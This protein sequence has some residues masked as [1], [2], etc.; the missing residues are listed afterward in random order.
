MQ[1][2]RSISIASTGSTRVLSPGQKRF[3]SLILKIGVQRKLLADWN[4]VSPLLQRRHSA[5]FAPLLDGYAELNAKLVRLLDQ[6]ADAKSLNKAERRF[7]RQLICRLAGPLIDGKHADQMKAIYNRHSRTDFDSDVKASKDGLKQM[8][9]DEFG[10]DPA[11]DI[12]DATSPD[13]WLARLQDM[14][15]LQMAQQ[16]TQREQAR[17]AQQ[18][19]QRKP[20]AKQAKAK[21]EEHLTSQS[22]REVYRKL[23]SALHPDREPDAAERVRKTGL[24]QRV[25]QAYEKNDLLSL[26]QLQLEIEQIDQNALDGIA[27]D[28]LRHYNKV[29][30]EQLEELQQEVQRQEHH[31]K[32]QYHLSLHERVTPATTMKAFT[33]NKQHLIADTHALQS[34]LQWLAGG[35]MKTFRRW[36]RQQREMEHQDADL[37]DLF[38]EWGPAFG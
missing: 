9:Q 31:F 32:L 20:N 12:L 25:N 17:S 22:I 30:A 15:E 19:A 34:Q 6:R 3:N 2:N 16:Q 26:L 33:R 38:E 37:D 10:V 8:I 24:M 11:D 7:L 18:Q 4:E 14:L 28:R 23:V 29:L 36:L 5:E 1:K 35:D 27:E 13:E 21:A